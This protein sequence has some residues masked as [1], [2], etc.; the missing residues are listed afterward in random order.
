MCFSFLFLLKVNGFHP[1]EKFIDHWSEIFFSAPILGVV[2]A[3]QA[4]LVFNRQSCAEIGVV[5]RI[6]ARRSHLLNLLLMFIYQRLLYLLFYIIC[7]IILSEKLISLLLQFY[8]VCYFL[9]QI[10]PKYL[11]QAYKNRKNFF[12]LRSVNQN[13]K[14]PP[15]V[16]PILLLFKSFY[17][18]RAC[19]AFTRN[20]FH[21][22]FMRMYA[23]LCACASA[24]TYII[25][26]L[27]EFGLLKSL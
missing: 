10:Q 18:Y 12:D 23:H 24:R 16:C 9:L 13:A 22:I 21:Y 14:N 26:C 3:Q 15:P 8:L 4:R 5:V 27:L 17:P 1:V 25:M 2:V 7:L 20:L 11:L 6:K 19:G